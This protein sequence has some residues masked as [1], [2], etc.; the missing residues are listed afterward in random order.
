[1]TKDPSERTT[2]PR[3]VW[4]PEGVKPDE[5][6]QSLGQTGCVLWFT[7]LSGSGKSTIANALDRLLIDSGR[8]SFLLDGDNIRHG[9]CATP[10][11]LEPTYGSDFASR[12][13]LGFSEQD[14]EENIR[15]VGEVTYLMACAGL[16]C[17]TAFVSPYRRDRDRVRMLIKSNPALRDRKSTRLN[18]SHEW[19]S[20]MPSSA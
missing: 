15:R 3:V 7:G 2:E 20:R 6:A 5:R 10:K 8:G 17:L 12:F 9:L 18:S 1:M 19:I 16:V 14:R 13:G 11:I 4:H